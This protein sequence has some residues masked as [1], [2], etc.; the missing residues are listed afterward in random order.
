MR[1]VMQKA[2]LVRALDRALKV[3]DKKSDLNILAHVL[4]VASPGGGLRAWATEYDLSFSDVY[5]AEVVEAGAVC[6]HAKDA[7]RVAA[8]L[9]EGAVTLH[10]GKPHRATFEVGRARMDL[11]V[12]S[13]EDFPPE[14]PPGADDGEDVTMP[15]ALLGEL[16]AAV[17]DSMGN[18]PSRQN[19][20]SARLRL[21]PETG[22]VVV[23]LVTTDGH[24]MSVVR[25][26]VEGAHLSQSEEAVLCRT[27]VVA[28]R[29][30]FA[31]GGDVTLRVARRHNSVLFSAGDARVYV[32][33]I[34]DK[35][36]EV[37]VVLRSIRRAQDKKCTAALA[38]RRELLGVVRRIQTMTDAKVSRVNVTT[39]G[40][41]EGMQFRVENPDRGRSGCDVCPADV[42]GERVE[43]G[44]AARYILEALE[45]A[46]SSCSKVRITFTDEY[47]AV[48]IVDAADP[49]R[50]VWV[51]M[52]MRA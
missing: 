31:G 36:P 21:I 26:I 45:A 25:Q 43:T 3:C 32:R 6:V 1:V 23:E 20:A 50:G 28:L 19:I 29:A 34:A 8:A 41:L 13:P 35:Y 7:H 47:G 9:P 24:R 10:T 40:A 42:E 17:G 18:D 49:E 46:G 48:V 37:E 44:F 27:G 39:D 12:L 2:D 33:Q 14:S 52:P 30:L 15:A 4:L 38:D 11:G 5:P 16:L 51:I 22:G